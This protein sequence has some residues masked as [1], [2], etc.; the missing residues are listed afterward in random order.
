VTRGEA[1]TAHAGTALVGASGLV[2]AWMLYFAVPVDE[3]AA[4]NHPWQP[5]TL[6]MHVLA[7]PLF[8]FAAGLLWVRHIW[9]RVRSGFRARRS[10][11]LALAALLWPM[12]ASGYLLQVSVDD[13]WRRVWIW[14]HVAT[15]LVFLPLYVVHQLAPSRAPA[16]ATVDADGR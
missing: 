7:A 14:V 4:V 10:T 12:I 3:F 13:T 8:V 9:A 11:G 2:Y 15:S 5:A 1:W 16:R 6:H